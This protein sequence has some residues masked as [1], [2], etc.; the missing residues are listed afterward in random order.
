M[1]ELIFKVASGELSS[2]LLLD[3]IL[4][5]I[6]QDASYD[7]AGTISYTSAA[8]ASDD[9]AKGRSA[10]RDRDSDVTIKELYVHAP[11]PPPPSAEQKGDLD[12]TIDL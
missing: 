6:P 3:E 10:D 9:E 1:Q 8:S 2:I 7:S 11:S 4:S 12:R 5:N